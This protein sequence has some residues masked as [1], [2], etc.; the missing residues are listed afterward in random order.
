MRP[1]F[2][3][4]VALLMVAWSPALACAQQGDGDGGSSF[5]LDI[6]AGFEGAFAP[7]PDVEGDAVPL[8][9]ARVFYQ[10][11]GFEVA[12]ANHVFSVNVHETDATG[13]VSL[14][15]DDEYEMDSTSF[16]FL[17]GTRNDDGS[18]SYGLIGW[19]QFPGAAM[20]GTAR[21]GSQT[22]TLTV[23]GDSSPGL[24]LGWGVYSAIADHVLFNF[25]MRY[26][27]LDYDA[28]FHANVGSTSATTYE[29]IN[30][31]FLTIQAG[32]ALTF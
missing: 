2:L 18:G 11:V 27:L 24:V 3:W 26:V 29:T 32:L 6:G 4:G 31:S 1:V 17:Y 21:S 14:D 12:R 22:G 10:S 15:L 5:H 13:S 16:S 20:Q 25:D 7:D 19:W 23:I 30:A 28:T 8:L 9:Y